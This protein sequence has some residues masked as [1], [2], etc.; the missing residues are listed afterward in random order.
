MIP[1]PP[2]HG[3]LQAV[4]FGEQLMTHEILPRPEQPCHR[5]MGPGRGSGA[6]L[7]RII[8]KGNLRR[9]RWQTAAGVRHGGERAQLKAPLHQFDQNP[10]VESQA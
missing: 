1:H 4:L 6:V 9:E 3:R 10:F 8:I 7:G 2:P 5:R